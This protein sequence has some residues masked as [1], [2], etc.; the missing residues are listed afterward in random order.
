[1]FSIPKVSGVAHE[2]LDAV[3]GPSPPSPPKDLLCKR[4]RF[5]SPPH[6]RRG[7]VLAKKSQSFRVSAASA[8]PVG[9][10]YSIQHCMSSSL[11]T[12]VTSSAPACVTGQCSQI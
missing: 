2:T 7:L 10:A 9:G 11:P 6:I 4:D 5:V 3:F 1:M 12:R 8:C